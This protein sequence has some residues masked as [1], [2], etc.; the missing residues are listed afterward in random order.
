MWGGW[1]EPPQRG[2]ARASLCGEGVDPRA[3]QNRSASSR[4][5]P[6]V[7]GARRPLRGQTRGQIGWELPARNSRASAGAAGLPRPSPAPSQLEGAVSS[8]EG[9]ERIWYWGRLRCA[10]GRG[11]GQWL[12]C[13]CRVSPGEFPNSERDRRR[14]MGLLQ[15]GGSQ[16]MVGR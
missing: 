8:K 9:T 3:S 6:A 11:W 16:P 13:L 2:A 5:L 12:M 14:I 1:A 4:P 15:R 7:G 10:G